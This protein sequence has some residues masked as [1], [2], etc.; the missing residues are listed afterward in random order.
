M[1]SYLSIET[2]QEAYTYLPT[3]NLTYL[4]C[5]YFSMYH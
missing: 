1:A 2:L 5:Q 3:N 4:R